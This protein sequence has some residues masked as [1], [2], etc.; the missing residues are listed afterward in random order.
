MKGGRTSGRRGP[1]GRGGRHPDAPMSTL[2]LERLSDKGPG[3][4]VLDERAR[5][6]SPG[7]ESHRPR[8]TGEGLPVTGSP[9]TFGRRVGASRLS[10]CRRDS[11]APTGAPQRRVRVSIPR[12]RTPPPHGGCTGSNPVWAFRLKPCSAG[13]SCLRL[14]ARSRRHS[15]SEESARSRSPQSRPTLHDTV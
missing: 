13:L 3:K 15:R 11:Q 5:I 9:R 1:L 4:L 12:H 8:L 14:E 2:P 7:Y 6:R 10:P